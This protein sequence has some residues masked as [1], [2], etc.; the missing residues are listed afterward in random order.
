M[1]PH[2]QLLKFPQHLKKIAISS[3]TN[4]YQHKIESDDKFQ[5]SYDT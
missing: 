3:L 4:K 2:P 1:T 5:A